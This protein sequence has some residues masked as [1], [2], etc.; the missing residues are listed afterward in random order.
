MQ[1]LMKN[2][3]YKV[4]MEE[5]EW[6]IMWEKYV[7]KSQSAIKEGGDNLP[8][9]LCFADS[10]RQ[11]VIFNRMMES[12]SYRLIGES[13]QNA[14]YFWNRLADGNLQNELCAKNGQSY[15]R[16]SILDPLCKWRVQNIYKVQ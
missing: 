12:L 4:I 15:K 14:T 1:C 7:S 9:G 10:I 8:M 2:T 13:L 5:D 6:I 3:I 16:K 11:C